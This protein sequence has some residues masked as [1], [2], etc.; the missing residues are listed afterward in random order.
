MI[1]IPLHQSRV[2]PVLD[3]CSTILLIP[4]NAGKS[5]HDGE[6]LTIK[7]NVFDLLRLLQ[8]KDAS[9]VICGALSPHALRYGQHLGLDF[10][11]GISGAIDEVVEAYQA[12]ELDQ[13]RFRLPGCRCTGRPRPST[14]PIPTHH[15][16]AQGGIVMPGNRGKGGPMGRQQGQGRGRGCAGRGAGSA[17]GGAAVCVCPQCGRE[18]PHHRGM[19][20][21]QSVCQECGARLVRKS[22]APGSSI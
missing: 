20:C 14:E 4:K 6:Q 8:S 10:I 15:G 21:T 22:P 12:G 17:M 7:T 16:S 3:W 1:A 18:A 11:C 13:P 5:W 19:P 9:P 2:A